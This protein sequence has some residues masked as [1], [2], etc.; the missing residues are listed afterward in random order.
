MR[1]ERLIYLEEAFRPGSI[2]FRI[3]SMLT[4]PHGSPP[5]M[6][7]MCSIRRTPS[8]KYVFVCICV[9]SCLCV[10]V[11]VHLC[12][13][14]G[15]CTLVLC[16][17]ARVCTLLLV[18]GPMRVWCMSMSIH[19]TSADLLTNFYCG[20]LSRWGLLVCELGLCYASVCIC[21][22]SIYRRVQIC[23]FIYI[24]IC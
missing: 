13:C 17:H 1:G 14:L 11:H 21:C 12:V 24:K 19:M 18:H 20:S 3:F 9:C 2:K 16:T 22:L 10:F 4:T 5:L 7:K 8:A 6:Q 15:V 23:V